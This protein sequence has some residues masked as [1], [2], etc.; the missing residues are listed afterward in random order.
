MLGI[1]ALLQYDIKVDTC[2]HI[3]DNVCE[4]KHNI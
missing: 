3:S 1:R 2:M 4:N